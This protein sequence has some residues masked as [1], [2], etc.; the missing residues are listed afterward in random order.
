MHSISID[1]TVV[2]FDLKSGDVKVAG[3]AW[4]PMV[5][6]AGPVLT[7]VAASGISKIAKSVLI[8][9]ADND[10]SVYCLSTYTTD[11]VLVSK[12]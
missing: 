11:Y 1:A 3:G 5:A 7:D 10:V 6:S 2:G 4:L 8:P 12:L 9:L